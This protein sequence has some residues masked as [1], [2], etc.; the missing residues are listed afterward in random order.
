M[1]NIVEN[2]YTLYSKII[3]GTRNKKHKS[4]N[5]FIKLYSLGISLIDKNLNRDFFIVEHNVKAIKV[6]KQIII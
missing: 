5:D 3:G 6:T 2:K 4:S 1:K